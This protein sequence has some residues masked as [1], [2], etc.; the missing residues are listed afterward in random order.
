VSGREGWVH[1]SFLAS[2]EGET[3][4]IRSYTGRE[5]TV[6]AGERARVEDELDGWVWVRLEDGRT[7]W[8]PSSHAL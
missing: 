3:H 5:V 2:R 1:G 8:I 4:S 7:G 6:A